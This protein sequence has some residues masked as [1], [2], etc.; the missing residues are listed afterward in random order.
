MTVNLAHI[1]LSP[2]S[3][4]LL[5]WLLVSLTGCEALYQSYTFT[6]PMSTTMP[7][8][9]TG[10]EIWITSLPVG[11]EVYIQ[12]Y[13]PEQVPSHATDPEAMRGKTPLR[14]TLPPGSYWLELVLDADVFESYF[15]P[16]YD[17]AQFEQD[18]AS[19]EALL[20]RPFAAGEKRRVIRYYRLEKQAQQGQT[21]IALFHP[22]GAPLERVA[23]LY[24]SG[25]NYRFA[26]EELRDLLQRVQVPPEVQTN[27]LTLLRR[28]GKA[29][30]SI[31]DEY[32][33][34][35]EVRLQVIE[36]RV[37]A[38]YTGTAPPDPLIPDGG[39]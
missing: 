9:V 20:L 37:V 15:T 12:S 30:W 22:R 38:L 2:W 18:G 5:C 10:D 24:P 11:A 34:A 32:S 3:V 29:F 14:L 16:P 8:Q 31:R 26:P 13:T 21:L 6:E 25:E 27:F 28:G 23:A 36:G 7:V 39:P 4:S 33:V 1:R 19:S 35:L 17:D